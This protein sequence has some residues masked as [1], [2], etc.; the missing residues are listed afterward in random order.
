MRLHLN[1]S[2]LFG[3]QFFHTFLKQLINHEFVFEKKSNKILMHE[4]TFFLG[5]PGHN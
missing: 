3:A 5:V 1:M 4:Y 2:D